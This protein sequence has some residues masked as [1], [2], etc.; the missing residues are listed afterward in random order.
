[1]IRP[2]D[3]LVGTRFLDRIYIFAY[4]IQLPSVEKRGI[5]SKKT[6]RG[7]FTNFLA[8]IKIV[9]TE[10]DGN[11][12]VNTTYSNLKIILKKLCPNSVT[13]CPSLRSN[14][15]E[16]S[17]FEREKERDEMDNKNGKI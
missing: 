11:I 12:D 4:I 5:K 8:R 13:I 2:L 1:M 9:S 6:K 3:E 17:G 15:K 14:S 16:L 7:G 10:R